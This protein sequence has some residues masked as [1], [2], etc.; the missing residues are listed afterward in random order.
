MTDKH[1][2][3]KTDL[4]RI[5]NEV[6]DKTL[7]EVDVK[8]VF[9][10]T[11]ENPKIT[12][13]AGDVVEQSVLGYEPN[14]S[15]K[16]DLVVDGVPVEL[17]T[18]GV[19]KK[20]DKFVAKEPSSITAV[21]L[22]TIAKET[23]KTSHFWKKIEHLLLVFYWYKSAQTVIASEYANFPIKGHIFWEF[24]KDD[25]AIIEKDWQMI[26]DF[27]EQVQKECDSEEA[28]KH[29]PNL[30]TLINKKTIYLDT[31]PKFPKSPRFRLRRR[32]VDFIVDKALNKTKY[33][34]LPD[35]YAGLSDIEK[36]CLQITNQY[37][38]KT[39][40]EILTSFGITFDE[41]KTPKQYAEQAVVRMFGGT[42][43]KISQIEIFE[44][45]GL[46]AKTV[47]LT[48]KG[49]RT[50][51]MKLFP[52]DFDELS[53]SDFDF[54]DS[55]LFS[56]FHDNRLLCIVFEEQPVETGQKVKLSDNVFRGFQILTFDEDFIEEVKKT[57]D[58]ARETILQ[59]KL[60]SD[61]V[62]DKN[63]N[64][65]ITPKTKIG[66]TAVNL[67]K[68]ESFNVFFRGTGRTAKSKI[69]IL[70]VKMLRQDYW[71]RGDYI[72]KALKTVKMIGD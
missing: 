41:N 70:G 59:G 25:Q 60:K 3:V 48:S 21:S 8:N 2:F 66:M 10:R 65:R 18:T 49:K 38:G 53:T 52:V 55:E 20:D 32:V 71:I 22:K 29:Y 51:D 12:G 11:K 37:G 39:I 42:S 61:P 15:R 31:A 40:S 58:D 43:T 34:V 44:K 9:A 35:K 13:I 23:Y 67:P 5:L 54:E 63:G 24:D 46:K 36:K 68:A 72:A 33:E 50:E 57:W 47:A 56:F 27:V 62:L 69:E 1:I 16:P 19:L 6:R 14:T 4:E 45:F 26:H 30:S 64:Q 17:K 28:K 7:G